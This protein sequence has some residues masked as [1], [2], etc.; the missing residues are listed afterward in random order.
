MTSACNT[1][2]SVAHRPKAIKPEPGR[3][4]PCQK[5]KKSALVRQRPVARVANTALAAPPVSAVSLRMF[6]DL[7]R[8]AV[9]NARSPVC[10]QGL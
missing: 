5:T 2:P 7:V 9:D 10:A 1:G 8:G 4:R 6:L 3:A